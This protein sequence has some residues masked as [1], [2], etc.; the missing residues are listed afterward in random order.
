MSPLLLWIIILA[1]T[2]SALAFVLFFILPDCASLPV[3]GKV[4]GECGAVQGAVI[5][6]C[7]A[8]FFAGAAYSAYRIAGAVKE[9]RA[10]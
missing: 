1:A 2:I 6:V 7:S 10:E 3:R 8:M 9:R 4:Y 5:G